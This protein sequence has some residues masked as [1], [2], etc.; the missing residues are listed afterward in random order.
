MN[1]YYDMKKNNCFL[2]LLFTV[3]SNYGLCDTGY[4]LWLNYKTVNDPQLKSEYTDYLANVS[5]ATN[6]FEQQ[7][8]DELNVVALKMLNIK[9]NYEKERLTKNGLIF[10]IDEGLDFLTDEGYTIKSASE[11]GLRIIVVRSAS[12]KG[13]FYA[14]FELIRLMQCGISF[15]GV[16]RTE[17]PKHRLRILNH[18]DDLNGEIE[19]GYAGLSL[20]NWDNLPNLEQRYNDYARANASIGINAV[21][22]NNMN[23]D[24][25]I[26]QAGYLE[27][28]TA[29]A[30][31]LRKY[32]IQTFLS[33]NFAAPMK[34]SSTPNQKKR[35]GGIGELDT[36]DPLDK[37][38]ITWWE[39]KVKEIYR[40]IPDFGGFLIKANSE[41]MPGPQ[42]YGRSHCEGANMLA[43]ALKP[44]NGIVMWRAF[45]Y[46]YSVEPDRVKSA[47]KEF[48]PLDGQ[49]DDNVIIQVKNGPLD[50]QPREPAH[51]LFGAM[52]KTNMMAELQITQEY[53]GQSTY[54]VYL[55]DMWREFFDFDTYCKG[56]G[57]TISKL[58]TGDLGNISAIAG[59]AN[60]GNEQ[61][62]CGHHF[63]Q[64]NWYAF[65]RLAWNPQYDSDLITD[66]WITM[67]WN[68][69]QTTHSII[70]EM[71]LPTWESFNKSQTPFSLGLT[72]STRDHFEPDFP[73]RANR[74]WNVNGQAIGN[75]R[76]TNG[77]D[78]VSQYFEPNKSMYNNIESCPENVLLFF[79]QV[80]WNH[81]MK[82]GKTLKEEVFGGLNSNIRL[83]ELNMERWISIKDK[84]D[85]QRWQDVSERLEAQKKASQNYFRNG[86]DFFN[87]ILYGQ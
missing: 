34:P 84:I 28:V 75:D 59:V 73:Q 31:I 16:D 29:L 39:E 12:G 65:G 56:P 42:D 74:F 66:E 8:K 62:W 18:W 25:R 40:L 32:N 70:K 5:L 20:W 10:V 15:E 68:C 7:I 82:S 11:N 77:S 13:L 33:A 17:S 47:Y 6:P 50:F 9:V 69:D 80:D 37:N 53:I 58:S 3:I 49:F 87:V 60:T 35:W 67:T 54:L 57:S 2:I 4:E 41:G 55:L 83:T 86:F 48:K 71:M 27:K 72:C 30:N 22:L 43:K 45:V 76:T 63:A 14:T 24:P 1:N 78:F 36:A 64:A 81:K 51:P 52:T 21:V 44:Y 46:N 85:S 19:R 23:A 61:N 38:V 79:H 26:L